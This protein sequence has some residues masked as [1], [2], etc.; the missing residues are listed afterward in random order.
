MTESYMNKLKTTFEDGKNQITKVVSDVNAELTKTAQN[1]NINSPLPADFASEVTKAAN[2]LNC[3]TDPE[4]TEGGLEHVIPKEVFDKAKGLAIFTVVKAGF[5]WSGRV[6]SGLVIS[7][8]EDGYWS[9]PSCI[10]IG[11]VGFGP[12]FGADV[13]DF[14]IV[15]NTKE[16]VKAFS[17]GE[18]VTLGVTAGPLGFGGE[19][20]GSVYDG[21]ALFS[22]SK[23]K[24]LFAGVSLEGTIIFE[25]KDA[26][27]KFYEKEISA[28]ALLTAKPASHPPA[29]HVLYEAIRKAEERQPKH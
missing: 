4:K 28:E 7:K 23:S 14:L 8:L 25:R 10:S 19:V 13:T 3:F 18:N 5:V 17:H 15:L 29:T 27:H 21:A 12:Q 26:N 22:Y 2:I 1:N 20:S 11:G 6:G 9:L 24:G 16:A